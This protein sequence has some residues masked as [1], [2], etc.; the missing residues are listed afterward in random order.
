MTMALLAAAACSHK[1]TEG[2]VRLQQVSDAFASAGL[3]LNGF[4]NADAHR[5][6]AQR[7]LAGQLDGVDAVV[8]EYRTPVEVTAGKQAGEAWAAN[9]TTAVVLGNGRTVLAL[10]DRARVDPHGKTI[11]KISQIYSHT[12]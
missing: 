4:T 7:C 9:A 12:R 6:A 2:G 1:P 5:F 10:A 11:H 8:C 3:Q